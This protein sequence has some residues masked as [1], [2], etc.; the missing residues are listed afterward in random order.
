[1]AA[2]Q[3][4]SSAAS[5][6]SQ[7]MFDY[8]SGDSFEG[9]IDSNGLKTGLGVLKFADGTLYM[10]NFAEGKFSGL[11]TLTFS[12]GARF[13]GEF[14]KG[15]M[16]GYGTYANADGMRFQGKFANGEVT[17]GKMLCPND[18]RRTKLPVK[19]EGHFHNNALVK[20]CN[21]SDTLARAEQAT[22]AAQ[23]MVASFT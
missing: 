9:N 13:E 14:R 7:V 4:T 19:V 11:G 3:T 12:N 16:Q 20:V 8:E 6:E 18:G 10:G 15:M 1:M 17:L 2:G 21:V 5:A 22:L 23:Q